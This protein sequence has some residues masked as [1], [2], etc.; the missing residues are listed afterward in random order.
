[1]G[2]VWQCIRTERIVGCWSFAKARVVEQEVAKITT[3]MVVNSWRL[4]ETGWVEKRK[5]LQCPKG[6]LTLANGDRRAKCLLHPT[7]SWYD[8][9]DLRTH[10]VVQAELAGKQ[11]GEAA[12]GRGW[13]VHTWLFRR[14]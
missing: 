11:A 1:M 14:L 12:G 9:Q 5:T 7:D 13:H 4:T 2:T 3:L 8:L 10:V 6:S